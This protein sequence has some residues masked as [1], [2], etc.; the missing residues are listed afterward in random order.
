MR[1]WFIVYPKGKE[2]S[3]VA[4]EFLDFSISH[5]INIR[6]ELMCDFPEVFDDREKMAKLKAVK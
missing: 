2:L 3:L 4:K 5:E 6:E 1:Q